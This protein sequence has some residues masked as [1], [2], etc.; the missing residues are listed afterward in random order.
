MAPFDIL[1]LSPM[2]FD[3]STNFAN[4]ESAWKKLLSVHRGDFPE[5]RILPCNTFRLPSATGEQRMRFF[6]P[7]LP[8]SPVFLFFLAGE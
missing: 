4:R 6:S 3:A 2:N 8:F 5:T 1:Y 7:L